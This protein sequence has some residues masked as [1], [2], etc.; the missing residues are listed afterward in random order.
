MLHA[1]NE[2]QF[3]NFF[4]DAETTKNIFL[5]G[6][7]YSYTVFPYLAGW[8]FHFF[9]KWLIS[10]WQITTYTMLVKNYREKRRRT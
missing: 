2:L 4:I 3:S 10:F 9:K 5:Y 1:S 8:I 6:T 7:M